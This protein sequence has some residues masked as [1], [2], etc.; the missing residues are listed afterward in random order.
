MRVESLTHGAR[1]SQSI[2]GILLLLLASLFAAAVSVA[3]AT[4]DGGAPRHDASVSNL[5]EYF[6]TEKGV[7]YSPKQQI[8]Y[9]NGMMGVFATERIEEGELLCSVPWNATINA[10]KRIKSPPHLVCDTVRNLAKEMRLGEMSDFGPYVLYLFNQRVGQLPSAWSRPAKDLLRRVL[11]GDGENNNALP[12][13][14]ATD[15]MDESWHRECGGTDDPFDNNAAMLVIQRAE[16][17]LMVPV[18]D[19]YNQ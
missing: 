17:D 11:D 2:S 14:E 8:R 18:Y 4:A 12:P 6:T 7:F 10:G 3:A 13:F 1:G 5:V 9:E 19:F 16:D 15:L